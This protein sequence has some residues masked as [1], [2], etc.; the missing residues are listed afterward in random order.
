[1]PALIAVAAASVLLFLAAFH[2]LGVVGVARRAIGTT[3][4]A[5]RAMR[6]P[7]LDELARERAVQAA[8]LRVLGAAG[9]LILRSLAA[10]AVAFLPVLAADL[11]GLAERGA[12]LAFMERWEVILAASLLVTLGYLIIGRRWLR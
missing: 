4:E 11:A 5:M 1:M 10:L 12:A 9:G 8:A 2:R 7:G 6:D 3:G